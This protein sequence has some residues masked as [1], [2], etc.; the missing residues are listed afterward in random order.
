MQKIF[1]NLSRTKSSKREQENDYGKARLERSRCNSAG[2]YSYNR[3][4]RLKSGTTN[5]YRLRLNSS[6]LNKTKSSYAKVFD[7]SYRD[8]KYKADRLNSYK[9][10][11]TNSYDQDD[12]LILKRNFLRPGNSVLNFK[13]SRNSSESMLI[14]GYADSS[15]SK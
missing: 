15:P 8:Q 1:I 3:S 4:T 13:D 7:N 2:E 10:S 5:S 14:N 6:Y 12:L 9:R 11:L